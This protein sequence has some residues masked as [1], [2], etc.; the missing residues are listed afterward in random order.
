MNKNT[1]AILL[2]F[3]SI[4]FGTSMGTLMKLAQNDLNVYTAGFFRFFLGFLIVFPYILKTKFSEKFLFFNFEN[5]SF[6]NFCFALM[7]LLR[8]L[9]VFLL[10]S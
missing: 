6:G 8:L 3:L 4:F 1:F 9:A 2:I 10:V 5:C 7:I